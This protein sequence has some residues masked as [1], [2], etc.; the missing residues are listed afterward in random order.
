M[1][2][3]LIAPQVVGLTHGH[4][5]GSLARDPLACP[6]GL[7]NFLSRISTENRFSSP[8]LL[9]AADSGLFRLFP[10]I[11]ISHSPIHCLICIF[12]TDLTIIRD[13]G[14]TIALF[15]PRALS[16][17]PL[18][19]RAAEISRQI[20]QKIRCPNTKLRDKPTWSR[21]ASL[22]WCSVAL[23]MNCRSDSLPPPPKFP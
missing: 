9:N 22:S 10:I 12:A 15:G 18:I 4:E 2:S 5:T 13:K 16:P 17:T 19:F 21:T 14:S 11:S 3:A 1:V 6:P 20:S 8:F 23:Y 7:D